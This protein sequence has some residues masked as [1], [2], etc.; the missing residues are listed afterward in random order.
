[1]PTYNGPGAVASA[2]AGVSI[3]ER[4]CAPN[5]TAL[6]SPATR[7]PPRLNRETFHTS[8]LIDF[9]SR[10]ELIA[11]TGHPV[12]DWPLVVIKELIDTA[13]D[14]AEEA[15]GAPQVAV[16]ISRETGEIVV[17]DNGI[18]IPTETVDSVLDYTVRVS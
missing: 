15:G 2:E 3:A 13:I 4:Q 7:Q 16:T 8:R 1:M 5:S 18:G 11:Q 17:V 12:E 10:R 6:E 9:C 14:G